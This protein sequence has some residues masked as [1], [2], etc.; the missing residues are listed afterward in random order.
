MK[1]NIKIFDKYFN[2]CKEQALKV[3]STAH[4]LPNTIK[5]CYALLKQTNDG[6]LERYINVLEQ[7]Q[8]YKPASYNLDELI[9][10]IGKNNDITHNEQT[11]IKDIMRGLSPWRKGPYEFFG[12]FID[13]EWHSDW[14][15]ERVK[16]HIKPL[17]NKTVLDIGCGNGYH[18]LKMANMGAKLAIG[19]DPSSLFLCQFWA[20]FNNID[21]PTFILP[22]TFEQLPQRTQCFDTIFSMGVLY[23]RRSP[24]D[25]LIK[26]RPY[27]KKN[28]EFIL[29]TLI[30]DGQEN[31]KVLVPKNRYAK[32]NN[33]WFLPTATTMLDWLIKACSENPRF[34]EAGYTS[35]KEQRKTDW[36]QLESLSDFL[37]K[38]N[39]LK[40]IEGEPAPFRGIFIADV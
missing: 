19:I 34:L 2:R 24:F 39:P 33:V 12:Q 13:S 21:I 29:E 20:M 14:K 26:I 23:H 16:K 40:T 35:I 11:K 7:I 8:D 4:W 9:I 5:E 37:D 15:W 17:K 22:M 3:K 30:I 1:E 25:H 28:G 32:M 36:M 10:K 18:C 31:G 38:K 27:L 6:N